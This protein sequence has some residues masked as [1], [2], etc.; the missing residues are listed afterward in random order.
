MIEIAKGNLLEA[1]VEALVNTV[2]TKGIMGKGIALQFK[3]AYPAMFR[4]YEAACKAGEVQLGRMNVFDLGALAGGPQWILN[5]PTKGHWRSNSRL[6]DIEAGLVDLI[7]KIRKLGIQSIAVP[8]LGCGNGGLDWNI[9]RP[10]IERA[11]EAL[12]D[13]RVLLFAPAGAP[14]AA[15]RPINTA[16]PVMTIGRAALIVLMDRYLK[17]LLDP[18]ISLLEIHKLMYFLKS[19]GESQLDR[20]TFQKDHY[21]PYSPNLR[22]VLERIEKHLTRGYVGEDRPTTPIGLMPGAVEQAEAFLKSYPETKARIDRVTDLIQGYEDSFGLEL[23]SSVHWVMSH[24]QRAYD[25][26]EQTISGVHAWNERKGRLMKPEH[27]VK[28]WTRL[29]EQQA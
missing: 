12:P 14:S 16:P 28:A 24:D 11:F 22:H 1:P 20:L 17:G 4:A 23:L 2:N 19:L 21:G 29:R 3:Q 9:V 18:F 26:V 15:A 6:A 7:D 8:P 25:D 10:A 5:F 27:I 13:V